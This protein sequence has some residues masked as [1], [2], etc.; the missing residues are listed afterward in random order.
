MLALATFIL[1]VVVM[2]SVANGMLNVIML[3]VMAPTIEP[4]KLDR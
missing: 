2:L 4:N 3:S 1:S